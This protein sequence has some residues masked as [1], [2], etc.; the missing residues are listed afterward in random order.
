[1]IFRM[2]TARNFTCLYMTGVDL[3]CYLA[4]RHAP[5]QQ[6]LTTKKTTYK[7]KHVCPFR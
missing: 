2:L 3:I 7:N 6:Y 1:M 5:K 4:T